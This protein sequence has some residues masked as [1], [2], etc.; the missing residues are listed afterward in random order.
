[1]RRT[2]YQLLEQGPMGTRTRVA[3]RLIVLLIIVNL[4]APA[5][6]SVPALDAQYRP[7]F[8]IIE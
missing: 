5:L 7:W 8:A 2:V 3:S 4:V 6:E 1:L